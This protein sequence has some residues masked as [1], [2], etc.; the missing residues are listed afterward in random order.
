MPLEPWPGEAPLRLAELARP[1][2]DLSA[3]WAAQRSDWPQQR[4]PG[5]ARMQWAA[6]AAAPTPHGQQRPQQLTATRPSED[7]LVATV[8][9][10]ARASTHPLPAHLRPQHYPQTV[11][12]SVPQQQQQQLPLQQPPQPRPAQRAAHQPTQARPMQEAPGPPQQQAQ[13]AQVRVHRRVPSQAQDGA[14]QEARRAQPPPAPLPQGIATWAG[15]QEAQQLPRPQGG[16]PSEAQRSV[17]PA[18]EN[19]TTCSPEAEPAA[20]MWERLQEQQE[21]EMHARSE[22][23]QMFAPPAQGSDGGG[24][25]LPA[26]A[27][28]APAPS[29]VDRSSPPHPPPPT[30]AGAA[31][32]TLDGS[33]GGATCGGPRVVR[34]RVGTLEFHGGG[35]GFPGLFETS[36]FRVLLQ[37]PSR[38]SPALAAS[39]GPAPWACSRWSEELPATQ[40]QALRYSREVSP[41]GRYATR[42]RCEFDEAF[43][44]PLPPA[45]GYG[46]GSI[47]LRVD[48]WL[49]RRTML[50]RL[51]S[52]LN[53]VGLG[54]SLPEYDRTWFARV[55][56]VL[57]EEGVDMMPK[58]WPVLVAPQHEAA[59]TPPPKT[60]SL[61]VEW[62]ACASP[63]VEHR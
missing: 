27:L 15:E 61:G 47:E 16:Q 3:T 12:A 4:P 13:S 46:P 52:W 39:G 9:C 49:E 51:D 43:D 44:L 38:C 37:L 22:G 41:D 25:R 59:G 35:L 29:A 63:E 60:L 18:G 26:A 7:K 53:A 19:G 24:L 17:N 54:A 6:P 30:P 34:I 57:P 21:A 50:E 2:Q 1:A 5:S 8:C 28:T 45:A 33:P 14:Q 36:G 56:A 58:P 40:Q 62:V 23:A 11:C 48:V 42:V 10:G 31:L 20:K 55:V 32:A